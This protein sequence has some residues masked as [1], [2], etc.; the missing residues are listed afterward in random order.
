[1]RDKMTDDY[2]RFIA[3]KAAD[4]EQAL[5]DLRNALRGTYLYRS[6]ADEVAVEKMRRRCA[7]LSR[8]YSKAGE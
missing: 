4:A 1:M 5:F 8:K 6:N 2:E 3:D 7:D